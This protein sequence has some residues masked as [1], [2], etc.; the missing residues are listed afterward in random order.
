MLEEGKVTNVGQNSYRRTTRFDYV[1]PNRWYAFRT[2]RV[3][4][5]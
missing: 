2:L 1:V 3:R 4:T 5:S